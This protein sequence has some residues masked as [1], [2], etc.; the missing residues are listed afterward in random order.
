MPNAL[1]LQL[2]DKVVSVNGKFSCKYLSLEETSRPLVWWNG[3]ASKGYWLSKWERLTDSCHSLW[4][5]QRTTSRH[6]LK[7]HS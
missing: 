3:L 7:H 6:F 4:K 2:G 5:V 1:E